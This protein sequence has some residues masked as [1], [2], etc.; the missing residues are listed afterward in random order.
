MSDQCSELIVRSFYVHQRDVFVAIARIRIRLAAGQQRI[1]LILLELDGF[2]RTILYAGKAKFAVAVG[3]YSRIGQLVI[4]S[5]TYRYACAASYASV[6]DIEIF[7]ALHQKT[8]C[9][10]D[11]RKLHEAVVHVALLLRHRL[12]F[13]RRSSEPFISSMVICPFKDTIFM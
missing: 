2:L 10:I 4:S 7:L 11:T 5:R 12:V 8:R 3:R 9:R 13:G 6:G 1:G